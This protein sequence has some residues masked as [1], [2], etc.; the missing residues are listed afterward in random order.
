MGYER[1]RLEKSAARFFRRVP[2]HGAL[3]HLLYPLAIPDFHH[4]KYTGGSPVSQGFVGCNRGAAG[5][6]SNFP[7]TW[8]R[9]GER[10]WVSGN[11]RAVG[12]AGQPGSHS[13]ISRSVSTDWVLGQ[14]E[15]RTE[16]NDS[17]SVATWQ[18]RTVL[19]GDGAPTLN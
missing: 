18:T 9:R 3:R 5:E 15:R 16:L 7:R 19:T 11:Y 8:S 6:R 1:F 13:A 10:W 17:P 2:T 4:G 14:A 12:L